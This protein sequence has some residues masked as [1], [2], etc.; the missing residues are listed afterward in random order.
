MFLLC[1][2]QCYAASEKENKKTL[3]NYRS[4][5][6]PDLLLGEEDVSSISRCGILGNQSDTWSHYP[7]QSLSVSWASLTFWDFSLDKI[8]AKFISVKL[9][10]DM[11]YLMLVI[12][13]VDGSLVHLFTDDSLLNSSN[14]V[15]L[16]CFPELENGQQWHCPSFI[17]CWALLVSC[18]VSQVLSSEALIWR[19]KLLE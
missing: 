11:F 19:Q 1:N 13:W 4:W 16:T 6:I 17:K 18:T 15:F 10:L 12:V 3:I 2:N 5:R 14:S 9:S 7:C 8:W